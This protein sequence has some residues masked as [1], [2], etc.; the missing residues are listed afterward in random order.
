ME[1]ASPKPLYVRV[2]QSQ[3]VFGIHRATIYRWANK[4]WIRIYKRG[5]IS[6]LKV[7]E[8]EA[9]LEEAE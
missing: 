9:L 6:L 4:G 1:T 7:A 5:A 8:I 2:S 3:D